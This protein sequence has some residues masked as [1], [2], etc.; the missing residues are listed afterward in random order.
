[1]FSGA[2]VDLSHLIPPDLMYYQEVFV[3]NMKSFWCTFM[4]SNDSPSVSQG[5]RKV[6]NTDNATVRPNSTSFSKIHN[7]NVRIFTPRLRDVTSINRF[8][9][10]QER[11]N[12]NHRA[13]YKFGA[14]NA[15][16][17]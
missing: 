11:K 17:S 10:L 8:I 9:P 7:T 6:E 15:K 3:P 14:A 1:M 4:T 13:F 12:K 16:V 2:P 5:W